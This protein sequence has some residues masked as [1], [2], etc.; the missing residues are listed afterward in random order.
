M[1]TEGEH[2]HACF[3]PTVKS[4]ACITQIASRLGQDSGA[5]WPAVACGS[6]LGQCRV[7]WGQEGAAY[8]GGGVAPLLKRH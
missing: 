5:Q 3:G 7:G 6:H 1:N 4:G 2:V 8:N